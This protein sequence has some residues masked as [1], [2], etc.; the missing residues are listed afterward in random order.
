M[1]GSVQSLDNFRF[2]TQL[3]VKKKHT[4]VRIVDRNKREKNKFERR[5]KY[6]NR[7][8]RKFVDIYNKNKFKWQEEE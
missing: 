3:H 8:V 5:K 4:H 2:V 7:K 1:K 6:K